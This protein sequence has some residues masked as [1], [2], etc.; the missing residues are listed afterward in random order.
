VADQVVNVL[1]EGGKAAPGATLGSAL[2]PLGINVGK[3]VGEI[4][5]KT[6]LYAGMRV[7][8]AIRVKGDKSFTVEVGR[9]GTAALLLAEVKKEKGSGKSKTETIG[10]VT[11]VQ[12]RKVAEMKKEDLFGRSEEERIN[13]VIGTCVSMGITVDGQDPREL[14]KQRKPREGS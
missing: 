4:N 9:P 2:G 11:M 12:V 14:L 6:K 13:Q 8:V 3:V 1:V 10:D 5:E 7:P